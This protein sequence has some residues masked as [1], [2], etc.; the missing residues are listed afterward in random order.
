MT[1]LDRYIARQYLLNCAILLIVLCA[2]TVMVDLFLNL[3]R[4]T[5]KLI[6]L[7]AAIQGVPEKRVDVGPVGMTVGVTVL[8][9]DFYGPQV[10]RMVTYL[11]GTVL[12][13]AMGFTFTQMARK[14][15]LTAVL[16]SG[17]SLP[18][19]ALPVIIPAALLCGIQLVNQEVVIPRYKHL[20]ARTHGHIGE[21]NLEAFR[22][23]FT[24]D[25]RGRLLV[26]QRFDDH[27][28]TISD[29]TVIERDDQHVMSSII[30]ADKAVW[31]GQAWVLENGR[32][33]RFPG[34]EEDG[35]APARETRI[36]RFETDL[37]PSILLIRKHQ[38]LRSMLSWREIS[39]VLDRSGTVDPA[40]RSEL[41]RIRWGR[42]AMSVNNLLQLLILLPFFLVREP[43]NMAMQAV[44]SVPVGMIAGLIALTGV[45]VDLTPIPAHLGVWVSSLILVPIALGSWML[46]RT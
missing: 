15:E 28:N 29:L 1:I 38:S 43:K 26:A 41:E 5:G 20:I 22:I 12:L 30:S 4:F 37:D 46:V 31:D 42:P 11:L 23:P 19:L 18:R 2:M 39:R 33:T 36:T 8:A 7:Q 32:V 14:R 44:K 13:A 6:E 9:A 35:A 27:I 34:Q 16:A 3:D 21:Q 24:P 25:S 45:M 10:L 17:V 40:I